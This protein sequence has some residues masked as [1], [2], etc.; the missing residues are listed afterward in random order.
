MR[1]ASKHLREIGEV[2]RYKDGLF[3]WISPPS[4]GPPGGY[5]CWRGHP[6]YVTRYVNIALYIA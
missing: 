4:P 5:S 1:P 6:G 3:S 2:E